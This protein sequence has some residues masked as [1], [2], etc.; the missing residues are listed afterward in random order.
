MIRAAPTAWEEARLCVF[1]LES[2]EGHAS[3]TSAARVHIRERNAI[4]SNVA[5]CAGSWR[6]KREVA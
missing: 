6:G 2:A 3:V 5:K 1:S 4:S